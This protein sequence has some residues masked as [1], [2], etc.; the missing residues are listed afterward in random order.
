VIEA[1][2]ADRRRAHEARELRK[3]DRDLA[4]RSV[5]EQVASREREEHR[6]CAA[7]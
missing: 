2:F 7:R 3:R 5:N 6:A 4:R 1:L